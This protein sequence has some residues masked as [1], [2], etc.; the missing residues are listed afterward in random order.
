LRE[1]FVEAEPVPEGER[2]VTL[3]EVA[4]TIHAHAGGIGEFPGARLRVAGARRNM[5]VR[6][7]VGVRGCA[8]GSVRLR[9]GECLEAGQGRGLDARRARFCGGRLAAQKRGQIVPSETTGS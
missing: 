7:G 6:G 2:E 8:G 9:A 5:G 4:A 1:Q 3:A